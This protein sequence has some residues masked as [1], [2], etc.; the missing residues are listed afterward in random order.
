MIKNNEQ[1]RYLGIIMNL[2]IVVV[3][4]L[5][6]GYY[7]ATAT[8]S[9][10][11]L[12]MLIALTVGLLFVRKVPITLK[13]PY[14]LLLIAG[15]FLSIVANLN[16]SN[17]LSGGRVLVTLLCSYLLI[18]QISIK[19]FSKYLCGTIKILIILSIILYFIVGF[20][21]DLPRLSSK[22]GD[23][24]D[25]IIIT[26]KPN[27]ER[28]MGPFWEP[29]VFA[30][31]IVFAMILDY[32]IAGNKVKVLDFIIYMLGIYFTKS[33]AGILIFLFIVVGL[34]WNKKKNHS[35]FASF[36]F[37]LTICLIA[38][39]YQVIFEWLAELSPE[40]FGKLVETESETTSTRIN[41]PLI[42]LEVFLDKP[43]FGW[44]FTDSSTEILD[45][46]SFTGVNK[47]V[48]QTSTST[49]IMAAIGFLGLFYTIAFLAPIF[50]GKKL[51]KLCFE[52]K[53]IIAVCL[54]LIVNKEPHI[55]IVLTW[56][57]LFLI[58]KKGTSESCEY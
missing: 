13:S 48:A 41:G 20:G 23:Y 40:L 37:I 26:Q 55:F 51:S 34:L 39:F 22:S 31:I 19:E 6:S 5:N 21:I 28:I 25:L 29:G 36:I 12:I 52:T 9:Y 4:L 50:S 46:M 15:I 18:Q 17:L 8:D 45:R 44:G 47:V 57:T 35:G 42:N 38:I 16:S 53:A 11:P 30:S 7:R 24:L 33:T 14:L 58:N 10:I 54:L 1:K 43:F 56:M 49:Q 32:F 27:A 3:I 2:V